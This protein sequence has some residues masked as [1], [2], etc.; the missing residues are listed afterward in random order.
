MKH[1]RQVLLIL[2]V[3]TSLG[4]IIIISRQLRR[5]HAS[6]VLTAHEFDSSE[7]I[8]VSKMSQP[9]ILSTSSDPEWITYRNYVYHFELQYPKDWQVQLQTQ[10]PVPWPSS[11][12]S[13]TGQELIFVAV[14]TEAFSPT[15]SVD[16]L[17]QLSLAAEISVAVSSYRNDVAACETGQVERVGNT[18]FYQSHQH[19]EGTMHAYDTI[20]RTVIRNGICYAII[21]NFT[22]NKIQTW[23]DFDYRLLIPTLDK[24]TTTLRFES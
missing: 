17:R 12:P 7:N 19:N 15:A 22:V 5:T 13:Y 14:P 1:T 9:F 4:L 10:R 3:L 16:N 21:Y 18:I 2:L 6:P 11:P 8:D 24:V 20:E 23:R